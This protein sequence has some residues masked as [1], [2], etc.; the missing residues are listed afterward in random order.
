[1]FFDYIHSMYLQK[2]SI[3]HVPISSHRC[4]QNMV[5][6]EDIPR[7]FSPLL[8]RGHL[9]W[10]NKN[11]IN[12][13]SAYYPVGMCNFICIYTYI[14]IYIYI[15]IYRY[16]CIYGALHIIYH[17]ITIPWKRPMFSPRGGSESRS[18]VLKATAGR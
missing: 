1:M 2:I 9:S 14:Y 5:V 6:L 3:L 13:D 16:I 17:W 10:G 18:S 12:Y 7:L 15:C 8:A 11:T 4:L